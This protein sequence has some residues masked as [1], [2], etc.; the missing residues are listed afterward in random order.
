MPTD[1]PPPW[2]LTRR[3]EIGTRIRA[4]REAAGLTQIQLAEMAGLDHKTIHRIEYAITDPSL[5][6]L[7]R[8]AAALDTAL[9]DLVRT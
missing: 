3:Q 5:T 1:P 9:A 4:A 7:I 2:V 8:I 6:M